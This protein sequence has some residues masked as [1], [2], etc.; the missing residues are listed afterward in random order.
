MGLGRDYIEDHMF[1]LINENKQWQDKELKNKKKVNPKVYKIE[2]SGCDDTT[3][4]TQY[5]TD[6]ELKLIKIFSLKSHEISESDCMPVLN[7]YEIGKEDKCKSYWRNSKEY[8][9]GYDFEEWLSTISIYE[10]EIDIVNL[11][12]K[13]LKEKDILNF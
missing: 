8:E 10:N 13:W 7:I 11:T 4:W 1:E 3:E 6:E 12:E 9:C 2:L 5:L